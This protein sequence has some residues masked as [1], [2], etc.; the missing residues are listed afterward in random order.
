MT[1]MNWYRCLSWLSARS[2]IS[3]SVCIC[4]RTLRLPFRN[5]IQYALKRWLNTKVIIPK[6]SRFIMDSLPFNRLAEVD[7]RLNL[8]EGVNVLFSD[9]LEISFDCISCKRTGRTIVFYV[10]EKWGRCTPTKKCVG[11]CGRLLGKQCHS[12]DNSFSVRYTIAYAYE[13]FLDLKYGDASNG[14]PTWARVHFFVSCPDCQVQS[15]WS[16]QNN[17]V[18]PISRNCKCGKLLYTEMDEMPRFGWKP[19][20]SD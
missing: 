8:N 7:C 15:K 14:G 5:D 12:S 16:T 20:S 6:M 13:P 2:R 17:I 9:E 19:K 4:L 18:R 10:E 3:S 11:F 1:K